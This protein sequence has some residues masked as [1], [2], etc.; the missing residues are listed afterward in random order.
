[1]AGGAPVRLPVRL[2]PGAAKDAIEGWGV[3]EQDR[4]VLKVRVR[5]R[6]VEGAAN[7]ALTQLV[8]KALGLPRSAVRLA[9]GATAR[10]KALEIDGLSDAEVRER[11]AART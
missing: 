1:V 9:R 5:A 8:A 7:A 2:S 4:P 3:D 11:L 6:P 10:T